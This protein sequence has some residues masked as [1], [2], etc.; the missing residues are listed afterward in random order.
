M[1]DCVVVVAPYRFAIFV[2]GE[3]LLPKR[4]HVPSKTSTFL[5]KYARVPAKIF[6]RSHHILELFGIAKEGG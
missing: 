3:P 2:M 4:T 6:A 5:P 1:L